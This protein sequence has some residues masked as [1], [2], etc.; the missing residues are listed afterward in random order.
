[1][2]DE[3]F[4]HALPT[5]VK[6]G[7]WLLGVSVGLLVVGG[8]TVK[9]VPALQ[10]RGLDNLTLSILIPIWSIGIAGILLLLAGWIRYPALDTNLDPDRLGLERRPDGQIFGPLTKSLAF[11]AAALI[12]LGSLVLWMDSSDPNPLW[13]KGLFFYCATCY[14]GFVI[15]LLVLYTNA[16]H[17]T[18]STYLNLLTPMIAFL[19]VP[20]TWPL[21]IVL[22]WLISTRD[23]DAVD[24]AGDN[25]FKD[26]WM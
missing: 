13:T 6:C 26:N 18:T 8:A 19:L 1:M 23:R 17:H 12:W 22:N 11:L 24:Q 7:R 3:R 16:S 20:L 2:T 9:L 25:E 14:S 5:V 10:G 4:E 21:L 15:Y